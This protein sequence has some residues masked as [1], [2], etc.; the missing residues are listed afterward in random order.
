MNNLQSSISDKNRY[1][2]QKYFNLQPGYVLHHKDPSWRHN[3]I[4]RYIQWNPDDLVVM[5]RSEHARLHA[6]LTCNAKDKHWTLSEET[7]RNQSKAQK[8][9]V[10]SEET[11]RKM[12]KSA[13]GRVFSEEHKKH[14]SEAHK[15]PNKGKHRVYRED[16]T[17]YYA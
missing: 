4:E 10:V 3:D 13:K 9:K 15:R 6:S 11:K 12:S 16:G 2:A 7:R 1:K 8:G 14:L 17:Y 5:T